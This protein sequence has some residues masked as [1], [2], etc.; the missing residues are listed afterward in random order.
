MNVYLKND[1]STSGRQDALHPSTQQLLTIF[2]L[3]NIIFIARLEIEK[4]TR[5]LSDF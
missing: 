5:S 4:T 1:K 3:L 2:L